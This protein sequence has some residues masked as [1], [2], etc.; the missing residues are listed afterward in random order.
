[1]G[2]GVTGCSCAL[3]LAERGLRV[4]VHDAREVAGG[5][6]GRNGGFVLR[7]GAMSYVDARSSMG[8][9]RAR[10]LWRLTEG[11][12]ARIAALAGGVFEPTGS[13]RLAA[14]PAE[15][16]ALA[17][18]L[19]ALREDGFAAEWVEPCSHPLD[20]LF[21][22]ALLHPEDGAIQPARWV[23]RLA[24]LAIDAGAEIVEES[25]V[26]L[27]GLDAPAVVV[28]A[29]GLI[30]GLVPELASAVR[31][32]R[33]QM[34]ATEPLQ[35]RL[36]GRPHY[37]RHGF[38]YWRQLSDGRLVVGGKRD[39]SLQAEYTA[40]EET[41]ATVQQQLEELVIALVGSRP[42]VT[43]R[44]A[45]IWG[46]TPDRLPLVGPVP[47]RPGVWVAGGYSGHGNVLGF[48]CGDLV[49]RAIAG[50]EGA[51]LGLFDPSR[52]LLGHTP[53]GD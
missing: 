37:A 36:Y 5:A 23:R 20:G 7:G 50:D 26:D 2:A 42:R 11:A 45:G 46:E 44:W 32:V 9:D 49:A 18:E 17:D 3:T 43:H 21:A 51:E 34:L 4:R 30:P 48:A 24:G 22:A 16:A 13:L 10:M 12:V 29:D 39:A 41:T 19:D 33:G 28:A 15:R 6:S 31:A 40:V 38:D 8:R 52:A 47:G 14:D 25:Q 27:K 53:C 1:V 35:V